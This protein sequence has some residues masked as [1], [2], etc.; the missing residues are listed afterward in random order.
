MHIIINVWFVCACTYIICMYIHVCT[1]TYT[2]ACPHMHVHTCLLPAC[3]MYV[4][5]QICMYVYVSYRFEGN[6]P[7]SGSNETTHSI[8]FWGSTTLD[9]FVCE[10]L[11][12]ARCNLYRSMCLVPIFVSISDSNLNIETSTFGWLTN[13]QQS[14]WWHF[15]ALNK[16]GVAC[17]PCWKHL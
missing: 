4:H 9:C 3:Y 7:T 10:R 6:C 11:V 15:T 5:I 16:R 14:F 8:I 2:C 17:P 13:L 12:P 1:C